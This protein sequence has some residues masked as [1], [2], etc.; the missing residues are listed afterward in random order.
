MYFM[1]W[2]ETATSYGIMLYVTLNSKLPAAI[3][4]N[5]FCRVILKKCIVTLAGC[6]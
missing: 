4:I 5:R 1:L 6:P 2:V 3:A